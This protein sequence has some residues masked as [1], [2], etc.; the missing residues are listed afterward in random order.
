M[1]EMRLP[2]KQFNIICILRKYQTFFTKN[3]INEKKNIYLYKIQRSIKVMRKF[4]KKM[5]IQ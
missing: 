5:T 2:A 1:Q 3:N 4:L